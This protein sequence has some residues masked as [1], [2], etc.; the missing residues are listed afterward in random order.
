MRPCFNNSLSGS[1]CDDA[2]TQPFFFTL[3]TSPVLQTFVGVAGLGGCVAT[4]GL[5]TGLFVAVS[6]PPPKA[7]A[8]SAAAAVMDRASASALSVAG[9]LG[10]RVLM[11][12]LLAMSDAKLV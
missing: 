7:K 1:A 12:D 4:E 10:I 11:Q 2:L 8:G 9:E 6:P 3:H 5:V